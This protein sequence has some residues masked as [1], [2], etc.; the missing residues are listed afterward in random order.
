MIL[1]SPFLI[2]NFHFLVTHIRV[3]SHLEK[4]VP[5]DAKMTLNTTKPQI[6]DIIPPKSPSPESPKSVYFTLGTTVFESRATLW[7]KGWMTPKWPW[8][9]KV[10]GIPY[11]WYYFHRVPNF[12]HVRSTPHHFQ[13]TIHSETSTQHDPRMTL[14]PKGQMYPIYV[15]VLPILVIPMS[16]KYHRSRWDGYP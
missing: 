3:T 16:P 10:K 6:P 2:Q 8:I 5:N 15:L 9:L 1:K 12:N 7:D 4:G 11:T 13:V 14:N